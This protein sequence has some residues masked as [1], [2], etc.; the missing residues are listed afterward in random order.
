MPSD[1]TTPKMSESRATDAN[2][3]SATGSI[4]LL[5]IEATALPVPALPRCQ[6]LLLPLVLAAIMLRRGG[7]RT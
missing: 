4:H 7:N 3:C 5:V 6:L 1:D 2:G